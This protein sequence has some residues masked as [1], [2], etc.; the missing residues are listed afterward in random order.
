MSATPLSPRVISAAARLVH[1]VARGQRPRLA[2]LPACI[3]FCSARIHASPHLRPKDSVSP[4]QVPHWAAWAWIRAV[5]GL[6]R[7]ASRAAPGTNCLPASAAAERNGVTL[8]AD[9]LIKQLGGRRRPGAGEKERVGC[10]VVCDYVINKPEVGG[11]APLG[12]AVP[13][14]S[15]GPTLARPETVCCAG[16]RAESAA[17]SPRPLPPQHGFYGNQTG[18]RYPAAALNAFGGVARLIP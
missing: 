1:R 6:V 4:S 14:Q 17:A 10:D 2:R 11:S 3:T 15:A 7:V 5:S 9:L 12:P 16:V 8:I 13:C 18:V